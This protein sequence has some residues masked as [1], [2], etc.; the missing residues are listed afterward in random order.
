MESARQ[1]NISRMSDDWKID[2]E[3]GKL[4]HQTWGKTYEESNKVNEVFGKKWDD[5]HIKFGGINFES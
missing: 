2:L 1:N 4:K 3:K 5:R